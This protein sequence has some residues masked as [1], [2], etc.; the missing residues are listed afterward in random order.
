[1][2][3]KKLAIIASILVAFVGLTSCSNKTEVVPPEPSEFNKA[4]DGVWHLI[5]FAGEAPADSGVDIY[6]KLNK[7]GRFT[8]YQKG[9]NNM[10][11]VKL[12]GDFVI[13][14]NAGEYVFSGKYDD[15]TLTNTYYIEL[16]QDKSQLFLDSK[17]DTTDSSVYNREEYIPALVLANL[18]PDS[19]AEGEA[20]VPL[21]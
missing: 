10:R 17:T 12:E 18:A 15:G 21:F 14:E 4:I 1:M 2:I 7:S 6:L 11:Y 8:S 9:I 16:G 13:T 5:D 20:F 3:M 19:R